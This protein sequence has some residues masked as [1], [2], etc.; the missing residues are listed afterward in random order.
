MVTWK[1]GQ[2]LNHYSRQPVSQPIDN[3]SLFL[4]SIKIIKQNLMKIAPLSA[5]NLTQS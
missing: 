2:P 1:D 4:K 3:H 5:F